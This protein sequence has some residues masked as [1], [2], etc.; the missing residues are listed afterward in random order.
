MLSIAGK[1]CV[2]SGFEVLYLLSSEL[3]PT[4]VRNVGMG[5]SSACARAG[6]MVAPYIVQ[7]VSGFYS[8]TTILTQSCICLNMLQLFIFR[9]NFDCLTAEIY[10]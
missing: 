1:L 5:A 2:S 4:V 7:L 10:C 8:F 3:F 6:S 9:M